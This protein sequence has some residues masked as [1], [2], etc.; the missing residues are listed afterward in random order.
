MTQLSYDAYI[1]IEYY[2][3]TTSIY[4]TSILTMYLRLRFQR[5]QSLQVTR[6]AGNELFIAQTLLVY[7][8]SHR[9]PRMPTIAVK[10]FISY[11][12]SPSASNTSNSQNIARRR[13]PV[14]GTPQ[15]LSTMDYNNPY[16]TR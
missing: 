9:E 11:T 8:T 5:S 3:D 7:V 1:P 13:L 10:P 16:L 12:I 15:C 4:L 14:L 6:K 2:M